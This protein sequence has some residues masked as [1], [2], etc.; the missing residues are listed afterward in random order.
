MRMG[1]WMRRGALPLLTASALLVSGCLATGPEKTLG[2]MADALD[3]N[4]AKAFL[5]LMDGKLMA[6][7]EVEN[8]VREDR[9]LGV[10]DSLGKRFRPGGV[11]DLLGRMLD[12]E[13][14]LVQD[15]R[16]GVSTGTMMAECRS[17][18][19]PGCP[20]A[21]ESL[22]AAEVREISP[23]AAVARVVTPTRM[24]TWLAL[25]K[26]GEQWR[27]VGKASLESTA[28]DYALGKGEE[29]TAPKPKPEEKPAGS[30][31]AVRM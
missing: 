4:D 14:E 16:E 22:K 11:Q 26:Q 30:G 19:T 6:R 28:R 9:A 23:E 2:E 25:R 12:V 5:A 17:A 18:G 31:E 29:K 21:P 27:V 7:H 24:T 1:S 15:Y 20:W 13:R 3:K 10:L 8:M